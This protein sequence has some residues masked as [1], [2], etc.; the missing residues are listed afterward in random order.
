VFGSPQQLLVAKS[1]KKPK[2][3]G[4]LS[5]SSHVTTMLS[6]VGCTHSIVFSK[7]KRCLSVSLVSAHRHSAATHQVQVVD[8]VFDF[9]QTRPDQTRPD[10]CL[11]GQQLANGIL[12]FKG[13][14][15]SKNASLHTIR[16]YYNCSGGSV[17]TDTAQIHKST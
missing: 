15:T 4:T 3:T 9:D 1:C 17:W 14:R 2:Q 8:A 11:P 10:P 5:L 6:P 16:I 12:F 7:R 13:T